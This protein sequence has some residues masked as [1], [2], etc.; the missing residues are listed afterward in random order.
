M[1]QIIATPVDRQTQ[2]WN[3]T[4]PNPIQV[5]AQ[6]PQQMELDAAYIEVELPSRYKFYDFK[7]LYARPFKQKHLRK[8]IQAQSSKHPRYMAE[9]LNSCLACEKGYTDI[10]YRLCQ[11]DF[12]YLLYW[13]RLVSFP[14]ISYSQM[15]E[16]RN[17]EHLQMVKDGKLPAS[18]LVFP[19]PVTKMNLETVYLDEKAEYDFE[20]FIPQRLKDEYAKVEMHVPYMED[21]LQLLE[22]AEVEVGGNENEGIAWF[23][24]GLPATMLNLTTK[25]GKVLTLKE[26]FE[27]VDNLDPEE[28]MLMHSV[29]SVVPDFGVIQKI[30]TRCP[31]CGAVSTMELVLNAHTFLPESYLAAGA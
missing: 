4:N 12:T 1:Q 7:K 28:A 31:R 24:T 15:C 6:P 30:K 2:T 17:P 5:P 16:C 8:I 14:N 18:S 19:Q 27:V 26:R 23:L 20:P 29:K 9:V 11:E 22:F 21:Y 3:R 13:E 10:V 25:E